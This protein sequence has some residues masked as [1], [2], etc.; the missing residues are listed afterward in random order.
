LDRDSLPY[1]P[2]VFINSHSRSEWPTMP[3]KSA[4]RPC[5]YPAGLK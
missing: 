4:P 5:H 2:N 1:I 3:K